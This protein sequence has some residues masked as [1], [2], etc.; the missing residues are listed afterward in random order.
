MENIRKLRIT[1]PEEETYVLGEPMHIHQGDLALGRFDPVLVSPDGTEVH[2][3]YFIP[4]RAD[5]E[6]ARRLGRLIL[7]EVLAYIVDH[8]ASIQAVSFALGRQIDI[9]RD[10]SQLAVARSIL[11]QSIGAAHV[12]VRPLS[13]YHRSGEFVVTG[14]WEYNPPNLRAFNEV[15]DAERATCESEEASIEAPS[16]RLERWLKRLLSRAT[17]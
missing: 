11:L 3:E 4:A 7:L 12:M 1:G 5:A 17:S 10:G 15:L 2:I 16:P 13:A 9:R 14:L 8:F 6:T